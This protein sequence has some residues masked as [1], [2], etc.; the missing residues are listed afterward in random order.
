MIKAYNFIQLLNKNNIKFFT[1]VPDSK[2]QSFCDKLIEMF[3]LSDYHI[4][5]AN[6]GNAV[7]LAAGYHLATGNYPC[8]YLQNSGI[9][10]IVNPVASLLNE[11]IYS[12]PVLF[13]IGW[14]GEPNIKDE[15]QHIFQGEI[16]LKLLDDLNIEYIV[17]D[18]DKNEKDIINYLNKF[19][20]I[21]SEGKS[22]AFVIREGVF[23]KEK[24][25]DYK[26]NNTLIREKA[27]EIIT[28]YSKDDIIVSTTG[29]ISRELFEIRERKN[30]GHRRDFLT[31]GSM[32]HSS[33]IALS[34]A[35]QL[36]DKRI[37]CLDGDGALLMH[38]GASAIIANKK[39]KNF[40]HIVLNNEAHESV[41]GMPTI[42]GNLDLCKISKDLGYKESY[43]VETE[44]ELENILKSIKNSLT[45][46]EVKVSIFSRKDLMRP[47]I[48]PI[49]NKNNFIKFL[50][51]N[52]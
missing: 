49:E 50:R 15:P 44:E 21:L 26:N 25:I 3:G 39:P 6:E 30:A 5:A 45:F 31:V 10:N 19:K 35:L 27:I 42:C 8:V 13:I 51:E 48:S 34:I 52:K 41:G 28:E 14:R 22:C 9:G 12:I 17:L 24:L 4:I 16:T 29:K 23:E 47:N 11:K 7:G 36:K 32:G 40:I 37:Y 38:F 1:G 33:M 2:L 20:N 18:K 46:I 43:K